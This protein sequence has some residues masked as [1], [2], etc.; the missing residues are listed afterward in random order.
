MK[1][2]S[3]KS[4]VRQ[5]QRDNYELSRKNVELERIERCYNIAIE[6]LETT[7]QSCESAL[8]Y[9]DTKLDEA[10]HAVGVL[11]LRLGVDK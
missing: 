4:L 5:L 6:H 10:I 9:K 8:L 11:S 1:K 7:L 3:L 2:E